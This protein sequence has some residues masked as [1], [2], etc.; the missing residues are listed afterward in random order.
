MTLDDEA[1]WPGTVDALSYSARPEP[2]AG[3][4]RIDGD[5]DFRGVLRSFPQA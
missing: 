2:P 4:R 5:L 1:G 3:R